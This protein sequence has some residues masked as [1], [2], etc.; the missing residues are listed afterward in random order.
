[1]AS[2]GTVPIVSAHFRSLLIPWQ[3]P[4]E[5]LYA[6]SASR[7]YFCGQFHSK[8]PVS[9]AIEGTDLSQP[10]DE[11]ISHS[12][13]AASLWVG[14]AAGAVDW[15]VPWDDDGASSISPSVFLASRRRRHRTAVRQKP[16]TTLSPYPSKTAIS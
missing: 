7:P 4:F 11:T 1:M 16:R 2:P 13:S 14:D 12:V 10:R 9:S 8:R 6:V 15:S 5:I 3:T